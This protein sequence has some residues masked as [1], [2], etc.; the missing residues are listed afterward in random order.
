MAVVFAGPSFLKRDLANIDTALFDLRP[1]V[2]RGDVPQAIADGHTLVGI[3]DGEFYQRLAVSPKEVL[4]ALNAGVTVVGG[5][6]M[7][8]LRAAE[9]HPYGMV[10]IGQIYQWYRTGAVTRDDDVGV[11]YAVD[12][13]GDYRLLSTPMVNV[14]WVTRTAAAAG[15]LDPA[16]RR[17]ITL[18]ARRIPWAERTWRGVCLA[19]GLRDDLTRRLLHYA[20]DPEHDRKRLDALAVVD[21]LAS[22]LSGTTSNRI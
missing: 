9:L 5:A 4:A 22:V 18:A 19:A 1:P 20:A 14:M 16:T 15:W 8:A 7:G 10:G 6:S 21:S 12:D 3:I 2:K 17:R 11:T 13:D